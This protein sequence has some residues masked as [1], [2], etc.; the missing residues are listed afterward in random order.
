MADLGLA[1]VRTKRQGFPLPE[2]TR[3]FF[4]FLGMA[5]ALTQA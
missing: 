5:L 4:S 2:P 3:G 1:W